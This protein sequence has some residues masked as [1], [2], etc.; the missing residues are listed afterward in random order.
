MARFWW[1]VAVLVLGACERRVTL[2]ELHQR[3]KGRSMAEV[4]SSTPPMPPPELF[5]LVHYPAP[6]GEN[7]AYVTPVRP[8]GRRPAVLW[9]AGGFDFGMET[10]PGRPQSGATTSPRVPFARPAWS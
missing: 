6:L 5:E 10:A 9:V 7:P 3:L 1:V 8:G 2:P 4:D